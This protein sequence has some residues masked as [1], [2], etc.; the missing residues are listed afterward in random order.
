VTGITAVSSTESDVEVLSPNADLVAK[1]LA[2]RTSVAPTVALTVTLRDDGVDTAVTCT[3]AALSTTCDSA[4]LSAT[5]LAG[6]R[7]SLKISSTG[8]PSS[9]SLLIGWEAA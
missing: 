2:V 7:L 4:S 9:L 8:V 1:D 3:I 6:S 5:I